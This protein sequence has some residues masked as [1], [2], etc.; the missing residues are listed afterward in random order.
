MKVDIV[1]Y[2][3]GSA[4]CLHVFPGRLLTFLVEFEVCKHSFSHHKRLCS[5]DDVNLPCVNMIRY[6][7]QTAQ[8]W[9]YYLLKCFWWGPRLWWGLF[10]GVSLMWCFWC[11]FLIECLWCDTFDRVSSMGS[12]WR[13]CLWW[14]SLMG[15]FDVMFLVGV[16]NEVH[17]MW[18][19]WLSAFDRLMF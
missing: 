18:W 10:D 19:L 15:A 17:L 3:L 12:L 2:V 5:C 1:F 16:F 11:E 13:G 9:F 4:L 6:A 8:P 14:V 7:D